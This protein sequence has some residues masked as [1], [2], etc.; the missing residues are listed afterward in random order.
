M[1]K[2]EM[3]NDVP[4]PN[5]GTYCP[6]WHIHGLKGDCYTFSRQKLSRSVVDAY[7]LFREFQNI[8]NKGEIP[9]ILE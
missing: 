4:E 1:D 2:N 7:K 5:C 9:K 3:A 8:W 6:R